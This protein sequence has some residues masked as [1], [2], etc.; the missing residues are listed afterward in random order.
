MALSRAH[1]AQSFASIWAKV[2]NRFSATIDHD[3]FFTLIRSQHTF[4]TEA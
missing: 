3:L 1:T 4:P 2:L